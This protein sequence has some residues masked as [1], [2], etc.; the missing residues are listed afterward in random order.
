MI[1]IK[2]FLNKLKLRLIL[3][4]LEISMCLILTE[5]FLNILLFITFVTSNFVTDIIY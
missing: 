2:E 3:I 4:I 1:F 5:I